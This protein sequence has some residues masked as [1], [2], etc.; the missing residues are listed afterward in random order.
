MAIAAVRERLSSGALEREFELLYRGY[1]PQVR[2]YADSVL[3]D[4]LDAEDVAQATFLKA[5][6]AFSSGVRPEHPREWLIAIARNECGMHFRTA[7]RRPAVV[8]LDEEIVAPEHDDA[9]AAE[10]REALEQ[11]GANQRQALVMR[12]F[13]GRSYDEIAN[14]LSVS[15]SAVETLLFRARRGLREQLEAGAGCV[16][17]RR[18]VAADGALS[19]GERTSLRAHLRSCRAC[20]KLERK[21]RG[22]RSVL[23]RVAALLPFP[24]WL[25]SFFGAAATKAAVGVTVV[26]LGAGGTVAAVRSG[27]P[28]PKPAPALRHLTKPRPA[29]HGPA[30]VRTAPKQVGA[31]AQHKKARADVAPRTDRSAVLQPS[32]G[33]PPAAQAGQEQLLPTVPVVTADGQW[34]HSTQPAVPPAAGATRH[35]HHPVPAAPTSPVQPHQKVPALPSRPPVSRPQKPTPQVPPISAPPRPTVPAPSKPPVSGPQQP[36]PQVPPIS[37]PRRPTVPAPSTPAVPPL[38][39]TTATPALP[40]P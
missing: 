11:L 24:S 4:P 5:Y 6:R 36:T 3:P 16:E 27:H 19:D 18:L 14:A 34:Q 37:A 32:A 13:E 1:A 40:A 10:V 8:S 28:R 39:T 7:A 21:Q 17:A 20:A 33:P 31:R 38:P 30:A 22:L 23:S 29:A 12:E 15:G 25:P 35:A 26:A 2:R 9:S